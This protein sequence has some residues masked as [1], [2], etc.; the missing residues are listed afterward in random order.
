MKKIANK[1]A[2]E[3][4]EGF[5]EFKGNNIFTQKNDKVYVVYSYGYHFPMFIYNFEL[6]QWF[7]NTDKYSVSTSKQQTQCR[8]SYVEIAQIGEL[9]YMS[10]T[11]QMKEMSRS[12]NPPLS[13]S[14]C[15][16]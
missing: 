4:V 16:V 11:A 8:P 2:R 5:K 7:E 14:I 6:E 3:Y 12:G 10:I 15:C 1:N 9:D 13:Y